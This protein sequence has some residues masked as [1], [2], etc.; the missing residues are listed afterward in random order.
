[1]AVVWVPSDR[2]VNPVTGTNR[3]GTGVH[4]NLPTQDPS[5][6]DAPNGTL[7]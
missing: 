1:M 7:E 5:P 3:E 2:A 4:P 6:A